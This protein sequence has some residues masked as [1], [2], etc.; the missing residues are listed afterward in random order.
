MLFKKRSEPL[1]LIGLQ[2]LIGRLP[3]NHNQFAFVEE[4]LRRRKAGF[5]G[6]LNFDKHINE[7]RPQSSIRLDSMI[8]VF[9]TT[10]SIFKWIHC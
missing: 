6:E 7:F 9:S 4:D 10:E 1:S 5:G 3:S 8:F 2:A